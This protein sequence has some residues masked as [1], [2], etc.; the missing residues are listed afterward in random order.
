MKSNYKTSLFH[1]AVTAAIVIIVSIIAI[2]FVL[3]ERQINQLRDKL[4]KANAYCEKTE[5]ELTKIKQEYE[6]LLNK[7]AELEQTKAEEKNAKIAYL[8]FDDGPSENTLKILD[9]LDKYN[10]KATFFVIGSSNRI[11]PYVLRRLVDDGHAVGNHTYSHKYSEIYSS[12]QQFW[13]EYEKNDEV[14]FSATGKHFDIMRFPG[15]SNNTVS[16]RYNRNIMSE[17]T[18]QAKQRGIVYFDWNVSSTDA[19]RVLQSKEKIIS[20]TLS[21]C[22]SKQHAIILMHDNKA[23]TTTVEALPIIIDALKSQGF[24]FKTLNPDVEPVQF[25]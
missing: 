9:I 18:A 4:T 5:S 24:I 22:K 17:L 13:D 2:L 11:S 14:F 16:R 8:T 23:K 6:L 15:G 10:I 12:S 25:M 1:A 21:E 7:Y 20:A 3:R 19:E